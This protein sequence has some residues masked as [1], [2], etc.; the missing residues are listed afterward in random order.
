MSKKKNIL[1]NLKSNTKKFRKKI[2]NSNKKLKLNDEQLLTESLNNFK[3]KH[4]RLRAEFDNYIKRSEKEISRFLKYDGDNIIKSFLSISDDLSRVI[5]S[6]KNQKSKYFVDLA[7]GI[8]LIQDKL[9]NKLKSVGV[10][11][12]DSKGSKFDPE[13]HDAMMTKESKDYD[14]GII[15]EEFEKGYKYKDKV[16]RHSK[17]VVNSIQSKGNKS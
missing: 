16:I 10:E 2:D 12:F 15:I 4:L 1:K 6:C 7:N 14:D 3:E 11:T 13:L 8:K 17:V 9:K 5:D